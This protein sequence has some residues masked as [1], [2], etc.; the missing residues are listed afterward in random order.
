[1]IFAPAAL[2]VGIL[3]LSAAPADIAAVVMLLHT[4]GETATITTGLAEG[5][6][7]VSEEIVAAEEAQ[8]LEKILEGFETVPPPNFPPVPTSPMGTLPIVPMPS[9]NPCP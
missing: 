4:G 8:A 9:L 5:G 6:A 1:M 7:A 2:G 3:T